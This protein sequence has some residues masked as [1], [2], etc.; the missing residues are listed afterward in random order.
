MQIFKCFCPALNSPNGVRNKPY[1]GD[2]AQGLRDGSTARLHNEDDDANKRMSVRQPQQLCV[3]RRRSTHVW[4]SSRDPDVRKTVGL[5]V[6]LKLKTNPRFLTKPIKR[7]GWR[8]V[9]Q[10]GVCQCKRQARVRGLWEKGKC[11]F[12]CHASPH[13]ARNAKSPRL[14]KEAQTERERLLWQSFECCERLE[15]QRVATGTTV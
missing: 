1:S 14:P 9:E 12:F 5:E 11:R 3:A 8:L 2:R 7:P 6:E 4:V 13:A 10:A 15:P